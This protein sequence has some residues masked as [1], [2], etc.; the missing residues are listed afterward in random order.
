LGKGQAQ[1]SLAA[2]L[3]ASVDLEMADVEGNTAA[4]VVPLRTQDEAFL[5]DLYGRAPDAW[6]VKN[7]Q[8]E[9][10]LFVLMR[11]GKSDLA[12]KLAA[13]LTS[14]RARLA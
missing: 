1:E 7:K 8:G 2:L 12:N 11:C 6:D 3:K 9:T 4:H 5:A 10:A 13:D 14:R